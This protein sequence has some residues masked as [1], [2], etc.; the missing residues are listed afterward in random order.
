MKAAFTYVR[1]RLSTSLAGA[2]FLALT[3]GMLLTAALPAAADDT[4]SAP[5]TFISLEAGGRYA[6]TDG[7]RTFIRP[8]DPMDS[9]AVIDFDLLNIR[10]GGRSFELEGAFTDDQDWNLGAE[11]NR[12]ADF[13]IGVRGQEFF[14]TQKHREFAPDFET[15]AP[16]F[17]SVHV[18]GS[19]ADPGKEYYSDFTDITGEF[20]LRAPSYPAHIRGDARLYK[21]EGPNQM[22]YFF[23]TCST[24]ICHSNAKTR[25]IDQET[26]E[27]N[28]GFDAHVGFV[29][30]VYNRNFLTFED[31]ADDPVDFF[32]DFVMG[33]PV[34]GMY[35]HH[36]NPETESYFD[37]IKLN[38][39]LTN[40]A[41]LA[42]HYIGGKSKN[43]DSHIT[44]DNKRF[45][46]NLSYTPGRRQFLTARYIYGK[47][48]T[49][50]V[51]DEVAEIREAIGDAVEPGTKENAG[52]ITYRYAVRPG[53]DLHAHVRYTDI[54]RTDTEA[55]GLPDNTTITTFD[56]DGNFKVSRQLD[57]EAE[58]AKDWISD[59][60]F[61][62]DFTSKWR[63]TLG[64]VWTP[65]GVFNLLA[66][67]T[68]FTGENDD[69][70]ALQRAYDLPPA[71]LENLKRKSDGNNVLAVA[72]WMP[73]EVLTFI[74]SYN[75]SVNDIDQDQLLGTA[76]SP[77]FTF[78]SEDTPFKNMYQIAHLEAV[79]AATKQLR[80][81]LGGMVI[82]GEETWEPESP[83]D[84]SLAAGL[85]DIGHSEFTK[86]MVDGEADFSV[87]DSLGF[88]LAAFYADYDDKIH[89]GADGSGGGVLATVTKKW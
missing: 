45:V 71:P 88:T 31:K 29:D 33:R 8:Y 73:A 67:Y 80:L 49:T 84:P 3:A 85:S 39:N 2:L 1:N 66:R 58:L 12:G 47:V 59:P 72:T 68:G 74:L 64:A 77:A 54:D 55:S 27:Y 51:S 48:D 56:V 60:A 6:D 32:G 40:K 20:K 11:Y 89:D 65:S 21:K 42:L 4:E 86:Y 76:S 19:D 44:E 61:A 79:W 43:N 7:D 25:D 75:Y 10:P 46:A 69:D 24:H 78:L 70:A 87:S 36:V 62:T 34:P 28:L 63:Y 23:R 50:E 15:P 41:V 17:G 82:T 81:A 53:T 83:G 16:G 9:N 26:Q 22:R 13:S 37:E 14:H 57:L 30:V 5:E 35:P 38:T 18:E 52:E